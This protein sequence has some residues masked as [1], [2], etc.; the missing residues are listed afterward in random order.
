MWSRWVARLAALA[1]AAFLALAGGARAAE[2]PAFEVTDYKVAIDLDFAAKAIAGSTTLTARA[3]RDGV[4]ALAFTANALTIDSA[5]I[6]GAPVASEVVGTERVFHLP[7]SLARGEQAVIQVRYH[8]T[9]R[10]GLSFGQNLAWTVYFACDWMVCEEDAPGDK[11]PLE[12]TLTLPRGM[13]VHASGRRVST[14]P[15][16]GGR[17]RQVWRENRPYPAYLFGFA[18]GNW[19]TAELNAGRSRLLLLGQSAPPERLRAL[20]KDTPAMVA[21]YEA[22]AGVSLPGGRYAQVLIDGDE[23][24]EAT[25]FSV[26]GTEEM[27][28]LLDDPHED[29]AAAHE[30]AHQWWGNLIT[31]RTWSDLWI[32]EGLTVFMT[33][34]WKEHRWGRADYDREIEIA[35]QRWEKARAAKFDV[36]LAYAGTYPSLG[37]R[38]A[39]EYSKGALFFDALRRRLGEKAF[40]R[41]I[42]LYTRTNAGGVVT[43][44]DMQRA[45]EKASGQDLS[46]LFDSWVYGTAPGPSA[47]AP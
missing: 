41:G 18:A 35:R 11:A 17:E 14:T 10:R 44:K 16:P 8:G 5:E 23:A 37:M 6:G 31:C 27:E 20:F 33:A 2:A 9:P 25:N 13:T 22:K 30:L 34:A 26:L 46:A 24:Q 1:A 4:D 36:P 7:H 19:R 12:L 21:F 43:G 45:M 42:R 15:L 39:I 3:E 28:P 32:D 38:R 40:W 29:W 47:P